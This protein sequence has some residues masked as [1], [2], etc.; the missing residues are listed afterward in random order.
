MAERQ[1]WETT[2]VSNPWPAIAWRRRR[3][4]D[5][6]TVVAR[7]RLL[8]ARIPLLPQD[9][10]GVARL[11]NAIAHRR[12]RAHPRPGPFW[13]KRSEATSGGTLAGHL[14]QKRLIPVHPLEPAT[15]RIRKPAQHGR[16]RG[17][18]RRRI[19]RHARAGSGWIATHGRTPAARSRNR[20]PSR[21]G[22]GQSARCDRR[23]AATIRNRYLARAG[24]DSFARCGTRPDS[25]QIFAISFKRPSRRSPRRARAGCHATEP[26]PA[27]PGKNPPQL[28]SSRTRKDVKKGA[29]FSGQRPCSAVQVLTAIATQYGQSWICA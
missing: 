17:R 29:S 15:M 14:R 2:P 1:P 12:T 4:A 13:T 18:G 8:G 26:A 22:P 28:L 23:P 6:R 10:S 19:R 3:C 11:N 16:K 24:L 20:H 9:P 25:Q 5:R 27:F 21:G 7:R